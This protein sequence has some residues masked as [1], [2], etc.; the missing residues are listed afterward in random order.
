MRAAIIGV[1]L[2]VLAATAAP[3]L[4]ITRVSRDNPF[5]RRTALSGYIGVGVPI[6]EFAS[7]RVDFEGNPIDGNHESGALDWAVEIEH[8]FGPTISL[9]FTIANTTYKDKT[10]PDLETH[11]STYAGYMRFMWLNRSI[12]YPY[13]RGGVGGMNAQ[14]QDANSRSRSNTGWELQGGGGVVAMM[15]PNIALNGQILYNQGFIENQY[16]PIEDAIV[17][18]DAKYW[19]FSAGLSIYFP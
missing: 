12:V 2:I 15:H 11:L 7:S 1:N 17:G 3:A 19:T 8:Y 16:I 4:G 5:F 6:G 13:L 18:F 14:F 9:G 10:F